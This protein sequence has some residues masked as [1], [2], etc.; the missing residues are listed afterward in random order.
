MS[1]PTQ[2]DDAGRAPK[3]RQ[4]PNF[5]KLIARFERDLQRISSAA[6]PKHLG[7]AAANPKNQPDAQPLH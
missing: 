4:R 3:A 6:Q 1:K 5:D 7:P 2:S